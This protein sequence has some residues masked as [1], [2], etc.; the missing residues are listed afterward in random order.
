MSKLLFRPFLGSEEKISAHK[1][2]D[3]SI[4]FATDTGKIFLD[5]NGQR[6]NVGGS[7]AAIYYAEESPTNSVTEVV[8][9]SNIEVG[10][11]EAQSIELWLIEQDMLLK[12]TDHPIVDDIILTIQDGTFYKVERIESSIFYCQR[13]SISGGGGTVATEIKPFL[14][15]EPLEN[16]NIIDGSDVRVYFTATSVAQEN[17]EPLDPE[18][19]ILWE[20]REGSDQD[21]D[22]NILYKSG[23]LDNII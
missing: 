4:Y 19:S 22:K 11:E 12:D 2:D 1:N 5:S 8:S 20:L 7:G 3:G 21:R 15:L 18:L 9:G 14:K 13:L 10:E 6:I 23:T 17:G 16:S